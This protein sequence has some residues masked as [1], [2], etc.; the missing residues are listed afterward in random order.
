V[1]DTIVQAEHQLQQE[2]ANAQQA[3]IAQQAHLVQLKTNVAKD[4]IA[5]LAQEA[6]QTAA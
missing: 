6:Q 2:T 1:Q 3:T 5:Q 4:I